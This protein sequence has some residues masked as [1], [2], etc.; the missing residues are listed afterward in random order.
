MI[1]YNQ[2]ACSHFIFYIIYGQ[3]KI[4]N[5]SQNH[6]T[7]VRREL[8]LVFAIILYFLKQGVLLNSQRNSS[9]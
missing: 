3:H 6:K 9:K 4:V 2:I 7:I 5:S 1:K 8:Y